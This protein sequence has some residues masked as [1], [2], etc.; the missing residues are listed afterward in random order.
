MSVAASVLEAREI[1]KDFGGVTAARDV[2]FG[3]RAGHLVGL[4]GPNGAG[5]S[6]VLNCLSGVDKPTRGSVVLRGEDVTSLPVHK[7]ARLGMGRTFQLQRL[8]PTL[9]V[10]ENVAF[11]LDSSALSRFAGGPGRRRAATE[12]AAWSD[13]AAAALERVGLGS[14][15]GTQVSSLTA[16]QNR[17][18]EIARL[19]AMDLEV[20]LLDEPAAGLN[21]GEGE[22]L[23]SLIRQ[24]AD[25]GRAVLL[26]EHRIRSVVRVVD[27]LVVMDHGAVIA[28]GEAQTVMK[29]QQVQDAYMGSAAHAQR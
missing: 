23:F 6:T 24:L 1:T 8:F 19:V 26:V 11:A 5:K 3:V 21:H 2:S 17:L 27:H 16:G 25:E 12:A 10:A 20:L 4:I 9:T 28:Q 29:L 7:R 22:E 14:L 15:G 13:K 18:V